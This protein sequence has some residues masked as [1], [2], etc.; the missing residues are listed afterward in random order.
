MVTSLQAANILADSLQKQFN[1]AKRTF[2]LSAIESMNDLIREERDLLGNVLVENSISTL[3]D[4]STVKI[5]KKGKKMYHM[6]VRIN[7]TYAQSSG[8]KFIGDET[9]YCKC[10]TLEYQELIDQKTIA[11]ND[12]LKACETLVI[13]LISNIR[14]DKSLW[15]QLDSN[16]VTR[17]RRAINKMDLDGIIQLVSDNG[18]PIV[19]VD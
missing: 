16:Y 5:I 9:R 12:Y 11:S 2:A 7:P 19:A 17:L 14:W 1:D 6:P 10:F 8:L 18:T 13:R 3:K 15:G 4:E